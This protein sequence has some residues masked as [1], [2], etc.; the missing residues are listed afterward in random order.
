MENNDKSNNNK[1]HHVGKQVENEADKMQFGKHE[2]QW[3]P[4]S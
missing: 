2:L 4:E 1:G 3:L